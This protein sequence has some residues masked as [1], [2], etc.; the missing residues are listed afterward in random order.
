MAPKCLSCEQLF[1]FYHFCTKKQW[2]K[3]PNIKGVM[4]SL[5]TIFHSH[6]FIGFNCLATE[7]WLLG[8][9]SGFEI[10]II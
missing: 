10:Q 4:I 6:R 9:H 1:L 7:S 8:Q 2:E 5:N 3:N